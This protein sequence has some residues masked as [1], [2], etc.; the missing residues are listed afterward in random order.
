MSFAV[1]NTPSPFASLPSP[2]SWVTPS[3]GTAFPQGAQLR[4]DALYSVVKRIPGGWLNAHVFKADDFS[5]SNPV[6]LVKGT[7]TCGSSFSVEINIR[8][9]NP[10]DASIVELLALDGY[11]RAQGQDRQIARTANSALLMDSAFVDNPS[12]NAF[13][14]FNFA[15]ALTNLVQLQLQQRNWDGMRQSQ[16][17]LETLMR[18]VA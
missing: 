5:Q 18:L 14:R 12:F 11:F 4:I 10:A 8:E 17:V 2:N 3:R 15:E 7:D 9:I 1:Q 6:M 13:T 16:Q